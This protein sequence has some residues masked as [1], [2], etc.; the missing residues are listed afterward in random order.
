MPH[1]F[2]NT[3]LG[4][5]NHIFRPQ[6]EFEKDQCYSQHYSVGKFP[7]YLVHEDSFEQMKKEYKS[8]EIR[9]LIESEGDSVHVDNTLFIPSIMGDE[10]EI[11]INDY[12]NGDQFSY[13]KVYLRGKNS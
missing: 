7:I 2:T 11:Y 12:Y 8:Q 6:D 5:Y 1:E 10:F 4:P 9:N 3:H 13:R